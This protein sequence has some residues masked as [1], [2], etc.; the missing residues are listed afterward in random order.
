MPRTLILST[1]F[2]AS[3]SM[4]DLIVMW[5]KLMDR[6]N[7]GM[8]ILLIDSASPINPAKFL[9][10]QGFREAEDGAWPS[11]MVWSFPDN[12]GHLSRGGKDGWGRAFC[13]GIELAVAHGGYDYVAYMD[14][15]ILCRKPVSDVIEQ[16]ASHQIKITCPLDFTYQFAEN[17]LCF[18]DLEWMLESKFCERYDWQN[19]VGLPEFRFEQLAGKEIWI[20]PWR[21][22]RNDHNRMTPQNLN[23]N[24]DYITHCQDMKTYTRFLEINGLWI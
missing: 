24:L 5:A 16:M 9:H 11:K 17:G 6:L 4:R 23:G 3:P 14:A 21:G 15:D 22:L 7:P 18:L 19:P 12:V 10:V 8:D 13:K 2:V 20:L 1:C